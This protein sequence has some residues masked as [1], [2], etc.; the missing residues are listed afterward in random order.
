[1]MLSVCSGSRSMRTLS[2]DLALKSGV[3]NEMTYLSSVEPDL[4]GMLRC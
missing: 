2:T 1:M 4:R 3:K